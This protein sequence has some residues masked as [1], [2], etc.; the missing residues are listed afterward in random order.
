MPLTLNVAL[1]KKVGE[2]NYGSRGASVNVA[3]ELDAGLVTKPNELRDRIRQL[4]SV[5]REA[6]QEEL[7]G[8]GHAPAA[9]SGAAAAANN[10]QPAKQAERPVTTAQV[11]AIRALADRNQIDLV[12]LLKER[13]KLQRAD[14]LSLK[15]ASRLIDEL[16]SQNG[17]GGRA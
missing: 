7:S 2:P 9:G 3:T 8:G 15:E 13:F 10:G 1:T 14:D 5:A 11:R 16:K 12:A 6:V 4:F 17:S